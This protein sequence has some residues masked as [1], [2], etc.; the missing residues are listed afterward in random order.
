[1]NIC[2]LKIG[3]C[4]T[5]IFKGRLDYTL[6]ISIVVSGDTFWIG[7]YSTYLTGQTAIALFIFILHCFLQSF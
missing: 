4:L 7:D 5:C 6:H 1:M 3:D 2:M